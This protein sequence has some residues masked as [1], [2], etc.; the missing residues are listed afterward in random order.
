MQSRLKL[1]YDL[2]VATWLS[3]NAIKLFAN[4]TPAAIFDA[5]MMNIRHEQLRVR[6]SR[7]LVLLFRAIWTTNSTF[8][9]LSLSQGVSPRARPTWNSV[10]EPIYLFHSL[11]CLPRPSAWRNSHSARGFLSAPSALEKSFCLHLGEIIFSFLLCTTLS[12]LQSDTTTPLPL[13]YW[14][15]MY[16]VS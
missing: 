7:P 1:H 12:L 9:C 8:G 10:Q 2:A 13:A 11:T 16:E 3:S 14:P 4:Q 5:R 15:C 6:R